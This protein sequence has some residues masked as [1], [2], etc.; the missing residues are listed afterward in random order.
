VSHHAPFCGGAEVERPVFTGVTAPAAPPSY[1]F[2]FFFFNLQP[3]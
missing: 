1:S 2:L 3:L